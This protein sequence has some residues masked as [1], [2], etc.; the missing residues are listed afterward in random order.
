MVNFSRQIAMQYSQYVLVIGN[1]ADIIVMFA[2][3]VAFSFVIIKERVVQ[4]QAV[5]ADVITDLSIRDLCGIRG[6][7]HIGIV[8]HATAQ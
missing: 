4:N 3:T 2:D 6:N 5:L 1:I 8:F 7:F